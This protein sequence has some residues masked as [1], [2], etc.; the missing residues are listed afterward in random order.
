[1]AGDWIKMRVT[2]AKDPS[3][4]AMADYLAEQRAFMD[5]MTD[6]VRVTCDKT[7]YEHVTR[8]VTVAVTV[9][10]LLVFWG[11]A[12]EV[13]K[14]D[15][16]DLVMRHATLEAIDEASGV[17]C[18]GDAMAFVD[19]AVPEHIGNRRS[20]RLP[21]FLINNIPA[22]DRSKKGNAERQKRYREKQALLS[23]AKSNVTDN[24]T[25]N[26]TVTHREEKR[27][28]EKKEQKQKATPSAAPTTLP[29]PPEWVQAESWSGFVEMRKRERHPLTPRAAKLVF[30][31]LGKLRELGQDANA[32]LDQSTRNGWRD[33]FA[34][35]EQKLR[36]VAGSDYKPVPGEL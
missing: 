22:E 17:P 16:D 6:P 32:V 30:G 3:V 29:E 2:L 19:W 13:G 18:M 24:V 7:V 36:A 10:A 28:E 33:V 27:R 23:D 4:I 14:P 9:N 34:V 21:K 8:N 26:V 1:M 31:E 15:G 35:R 20:V 5:W 25:S 12:N 11:V